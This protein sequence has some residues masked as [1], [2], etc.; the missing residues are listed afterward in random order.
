MQNAYQILSKQLKRSLTVKNRVV[1]YCPAGYPAVIENAALDNEG[2]PFPTLY[3]LSC[4]LAVKK[5]AQLEA[6]G[7]IKE[8]EQKLK[9]ETALQKAFLKGVHEYQQRRK[10]LLK[11]KEK[12]VGTAFLKSG[13]GGSRNLLAIKCLHAHLAHFL[14][15]KNNPI[16]ELVFKQ[17]SW[18]NCNYCTKFNDTSS[19]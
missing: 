1:L 8:L 2:K 10:E 9:L 13:V 6:A 7:L 5:V 3:W 4:P 15:T 17:F 14:A 12:D 18:A 19:H 16:G 11:D